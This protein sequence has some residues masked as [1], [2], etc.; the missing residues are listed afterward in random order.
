[1]IDLKS[2]NLT[3]KEVIMQQCNDCGVNLTNKNWYPSCIKIGSYIC[4]MCSKARRKKY[5]L[6]HSEQ[7]KIQ[8]KRYRCKNREKCN[9]ISRKYGQTEN[10]RRINRKTVAKYHQTE[11][12][13]II[14]R[15]IA[16][17]RKRNL[18]WT[19]MFPNP[20]ADSV[21][22]DYHHIT[23]AHVVAIP[24]DLHKLYYGKNHRENTME[25][26]KQIYLRGD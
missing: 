19:L 12:G 3:N 5:Y 17:K 21:L 7:T 20:F 6:E 13:K 16:A 8:V 14:S 23:N 9:E 2:D 18:G 26:V 15:K 24:R 11:K 1:M 25:I 4:M 22:V 10:G